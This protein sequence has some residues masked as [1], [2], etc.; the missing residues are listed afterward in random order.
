[1]TAE[2][3]TSM[4]RAAAVIATAAILS[5]ASPARS[6]EPPYPVI[7]VHGLT[8]S[9]ART[10]TQAVAFFE[11]Q[12]GWG[13]AAT[14]LAADGSVAAG[15]LYAV[16][17][18]DYDL[19]FPSQNLTLAEQGG[20]LAA[21]VA[22]VLAANPDRSRVILVAHSMGGLAARSYLQDLGE[23]GGQPTLYG[24][25]VAALITIG[26]PHMG[27]P[28]ADTCTDL[29]FLCDPFADLF[30]PPLSLSSV[31]LASLRTDSA[32]IT[33]LNSGPSVALLPV[34]VVYRSVVG[35]GQTITGLLNEDSDRVVPAASQDLANVAGTG[36]LDHMAT[37]LDYST[38]DGG[39]GVGHLAESS[40]P[41][42]LDIVLAEVDALTVCGDSA[43]QGS[44]TCDDGNT[45]GADGCSPICL[46]ES[47]GDPVGN[48]APASTVGA[49]PAPGG[50]VTASDAL[51]VLQA[52]VGVAT[53]A[54][55]V[56]D[57]NDDTNVTASDALA[58]LQAA[59][60]G[61]V[62]LTCSAC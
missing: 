27:T 50:V 17:F 11:S 35:A 52:A 16:N 15:N 3:K 14:L 47:C 6:A 12:P 5:A 34:D 39:A 61:P 32:E 33:T 1:M 29:P 10:W 45:D 13:S 21:I 19:A 51:F 31:A 43:V 58:V 9:A 42:F 44:E 22:T 20:E 8:G 23:L 7:L 24:D 48:A 40:D 28:L 60:G 25:D 26:T 56:C 59:V 36:L 53:C 37:T 46:I 38:L 57:V 62:T 55:C 18:S 30:D 49:A 2:R 54:A 4:R 41:R